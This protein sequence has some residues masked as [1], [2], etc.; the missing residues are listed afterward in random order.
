MKKTILGASL[1][2][3]L[4]SGAVM[5][6]PMGADRHVEKGVSCTSCHGQNN[7]IEYPTIEQ[8]RTCHNPADVAK[9]TEKVKPQNPHV[10]P[11]YG[12][13]LDC[14]LC[15]TQHAEPVNQC[16]QCHSFDFKVK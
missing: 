11:H 12:T 4:C 9:K 1:I 14:V 13:E 10:S 6:A 16:N 5:A 3:L 15:H 2:A 8:C 7:E